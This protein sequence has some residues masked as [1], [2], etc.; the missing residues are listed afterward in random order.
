[1]AIDTPAR[2]AILGA[3]PIGLEAALYARYLG[4][5]VDLYERGRAC[6][7]V[8]R[9]G[10]V[11]LFSPW[12]M[13]VTPLGVA[14]LRAQDPAWR[15][16][17]DDALLTGRELAER[18][19]LPLAGSDLLVDGL[20]ET[21]EVV[22]VGKA[23]FLKGELPG[24]DCRGD[25]PFRLVVRNAAGQERAAEADA[26]LDCTG[27]YGQP[28]WLGAGGLPA[29]GE[30]AAQAR[31]EYHL[32]DLGGTDRARY[33]GRH[34]LVVGAGYSA[35]ST[36]VA[37]ADLA[38]EAPATRV[39]WVTRREPSA[40]EG[41]IARLADDPLVERD[42]LAARANALAAAGAGPVAHRPGTLVDAVRYDAAADRWRVEL[43][44]LHGGTLEVDRIVAQVGYRPDARLHAELQ[45]QTCYA[46]EGP[47][48]L[49]AHLL[50]SDAADCLAQP[51]TGVD[52]LR[53]P[54]P[55]Y[56]LLG[57]KSYGRRSQFLLA[58]GHRQIRELFALL[59][60]RPT[61]DLY[62]TMGGLVE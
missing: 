17:D 43:F 16:V 39:T 37:L 4:Y 2:I 47:L 55:N 5:D 44:G 28:N 30:Q 48:R 36:V 3:G 57:A 62:A 58:H 8:R 22:G 40:A 52:T 10:H 35:A 38:R 61:L 24:D 20:H 14:A 50:A 6:E 60:D 21:T 41:P 26:V 54:E 29:I 42:Q 18:Y 11:R 56:Y 59:G 15:P 51:A 32:P 25:F 49:A 7:H 1:M 27:T 34:T 23:E 45:V 19:W 31:I 13:N 33:L 12:R 46:T 9:W 53:N